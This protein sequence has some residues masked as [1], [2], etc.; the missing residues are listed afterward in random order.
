MSAMMIREA[1]KVEI[2]VLVDNYSDFFLS[3]TD[4]AK[5]LRVLP[6]SG[7]LSEPGLSYLIKVYAGSETHTLLFDTGISGT[8][9]LH[10]AQAFASSM[11]VMMGQVGANFKDI[12]AVVLSHG[13]FDH[14]GG[15]LAFLEQAKKGMPVFLQMDAFVSRRFKVNPQLHIDMPGMDEMALT[16][17]GAKLEKTK[18]AQT[19]A[20]DLVLL[21]GKVARQTDFEKGMPEME[22]RINEEWILD[23]FYDDQGLAVNIKGCGLVVVGGCSHAGIINTV[24]H[25]QKISCIDK[26]HAV[27]GGFHLSGENEKIIDPTIREM[28]SINPDYIAPMHCTG[29]KAISRFAEQMPECFIL[30]AVGTTYIFQG[31]K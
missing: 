7:P 21:S 10:N 22:A 2:V 19:I 27:L 6:P 3:D 23:P 24:K 9:L 30:N 31:Q 16:K 20:S 12:E 15:L 4:V 28:K 13:H 11:A 18:E 1:D 26:V 29:W 5:R 25:L 14:F 17:A 8:C